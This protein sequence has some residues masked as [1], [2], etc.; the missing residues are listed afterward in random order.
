MKETIIEILIDKSGSMGFMKGHK[1]EGDYLIDGQTRMTLIKKMLLDEIIPTIDY[2]AKISI[3]T[4][5]IALETKEGK[6]NNK[7]EEIESIYDGDFERNNIENAIKNL[8]DP[9]LG[10]TPIAEA[11]NV[12]FNNLK[13]YTNWDRKIILLTDG[14]ENG[15]GNYLETLKNL[16][17]TEGLNC[18]VFIIGI[19]QNDQAQKNVQK[20]AT[21][22][23]Y[24]LQSKDFEKVEIK[25]ALKPLKTAVLKDSIKN[26]Q[27][28]GSNFKNEKLKEEV[29][30]NKIQD[31]EN[32]EYDEFKNFEDEIKG[33]ILKGES[34]LKKFSDLKDR[35]RLQNLIDNQDIDSTTLTIDSDYS[36]EIKDKSE[37]YIYKILCK[38]YGS[39]KV[40]WQNEKEESYNQFD[41][42]IL[43]ENKGILKYIDCKATA[44]QKPTFYLTNFEWE[45]FLKN[46]NQYEIYRVY[47]LDN[48]PEFYHIENLMEEISYGKVVP[49]LKKPEILKENRV[50]LTILNSQ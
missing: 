11:L 9:P 32:E 29:L 30:K 34:L 10:G 13:K 35:I 7:N 28:Q 41:F 50:F 33:Y 40:Q 16:K 18:Q 20:Y 23:Y 38:K 6:L 39:E 44:K 27:N 45:F 3:R 15:N 21:G 47:N 19:A 4:F 46:K 24:N 48:E 5:R 31:I 22:G 12:A 26:Y 17:N 49:Y 37:K 43:D 25:K 8:K 36:E 1:D 14:E 2:S 42:I